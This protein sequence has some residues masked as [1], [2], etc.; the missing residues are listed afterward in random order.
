MMVL[1]RPPD[2]FFLFIKGLCIG[3]TGVLQGIS[4]G[5]MTLLLG[6]HQE[7]VFSLR[8]IDRKSFQ[9]L[10]Q[11]KIL[12]WWSGIHGTFLLVL[13][14]GIVTGILTLRSVLSDLIEEYPIY[15]SSFF[16]CLVLIGALLLL[17]KITRWNFFLLVIILAS[18]AV[19]YLITLV[20]P[21][22]TPDQPLFALLAGILAGST[23]ILPGVSGAFILI[24]IGKYPYIL[25]SFGSLEA[26]VITLF[27]AGA[28][29]GIAVIVRIVAALLLKFLNATVALFAGLMIGCLN[30]IWPWR[31]VFEYATT[32][33]GKRIPA[34]DKSILPWRYMELTGKDP[35]VFYAILM[36][37]LGVFMVVLIEKI[38]EKLKTKS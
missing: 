6:I 3:A 25:T 19:S 13:L 20:P 27:I 36:M 14:T 8:A 1:R 12:E 11:K 29:L 7:F 10:K 38:A 30:K 15:I 18:M 32:P 37:A 34:F 4:G 28:V 9:L 35:Q 16:F 22:T 2:Y 5:S 17:R 31:E 26:D 24:F 23:F 33:Q 21:L